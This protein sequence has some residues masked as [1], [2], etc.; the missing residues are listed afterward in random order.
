MENPFQA[1]GPAP[2][3]NAFHYPVAIPFAYTAF[4]SVFD[5]QIVEILESKV[6]SGSLNYDLSDEAD[7]LEE[8][9]K[10]LLEET[11]KN[12]LVDT[13]YQVF[14]AGTM[15]YR[16]NQDWE[17][18][19]TEYEPEPFCTIS[20]VEYASHRDIEVLNHMFG[21]LESSDTK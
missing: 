11:F 5:N 18:G 1:L 15:R 16:P 20:T 10:E 8:Y 21:E 13:V 14:L 9:A 6:M 7:I 17:S 4:I 2:S 3:K 19:I 12:K